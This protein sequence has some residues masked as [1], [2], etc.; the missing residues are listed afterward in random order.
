M[1]PPEKERGPGDH[2]PDPTRMASSDTGS[3]ER[4]DYYPAE[5]VICELIAD[6]RRQFQARVAPNDI[7][8]WASLGR[9]VDLAGRH[10]E[11]DLL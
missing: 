4:S 3:Q 6:S 7:R 10:L 1:P 8:Y 5:C 11:G 2:S 9:T